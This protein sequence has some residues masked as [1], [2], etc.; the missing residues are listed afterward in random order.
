MIPIDGKLAAS[1]LL[2]PSAMFWLASC[3]IEDIQ[4]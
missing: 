2:Y 1:D 4:R 3:A